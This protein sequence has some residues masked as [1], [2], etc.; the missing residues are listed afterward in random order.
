MFQKIKSMLFKKSDQ[1]IVAGLYKELGGHSIECAKKHGLVARYDYTLLDICSIGLVPFEEQAAFIT[2]VVNRLDILYVEITEGFAA[3]FG[4]TP[5]SQVVTEEQR[6][7]G[8]KMV[9][10]KSRELVDVDPRFAEYARLFKEVDAYYDK[11]EAA[12]KN[13]VK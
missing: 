2:N 9:C 11:Y 5:A 6:L 3:R 1:E 4:F 8:L 13:L 7:A 10:E 12:L